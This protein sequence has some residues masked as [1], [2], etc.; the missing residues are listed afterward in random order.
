[1][2]NKVLENILEKNKVD[3]LLIFSKQNRFWYSNFLNSSG[4]LYFSKKRQILF[5]DE[6]YMTDVKGKTSNVEIVI[7]KDVIKDIATVINSLSDNRIGFEKEYTTL[8][9]LEMFEK[10]INAELIP[11]S[12]REIR[13]I[14]DKNEIELLSTAAQI[15]D[16]SLKNIIHKIKPG[17]T[18]NE[19]EDYLFE[20]FK[21]LKADKIFPRAVI[22]SGI[23]GALPHGKP[24]DKIIENNQFI[25]IDFG[26]VYKGF[27]SDMTRTIKIGE[28]DKKLCDIYQVVKEAQQKGIEKVKP[29]VMASQIH[30]ECFD[31]INQKGY[32]KYFLHQTGH[33]I[34]IEVHETPRIANY[35]NTILKEGMVFTIEPGIY[36]SGLGG[37]RIEDMILVTGDGY[38]LL[39]TL[40]K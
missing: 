31:H 6:R 5:L 24:T 22:T 11:V 20:E 15:G 16:Q 8:D 33:G 34:G 32:G 13:M 26:C 25:T 30:Q 37:V 39:T 29:G 19:I 21:K 3:A 4:Y 14:K 27:C 7:V 9:F 38:K 28:P 23:R 18:E 40:K 2:K 35:D 12:V 17:I 10:N 36:I 1:M